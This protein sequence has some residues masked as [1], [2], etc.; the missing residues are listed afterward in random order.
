MDKHKIVVHLTHEPLG[1]WATPQCESKDFPLVIFRL[2][3]F[4]EA[5]VSKTGYTVL[6]VN[7]I[8]SNWIK[9]Q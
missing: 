7:C 2:E 3:S 1:V 8:P 5:L 6:C 4:T 9:R